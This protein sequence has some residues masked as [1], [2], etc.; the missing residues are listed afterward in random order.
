MPHSARSDRR[1]ADAGG[2]GDLDD[3]DD[4]DLPALREALQ[5][6]PDLPVPPQVWRRIQQ[7]TRNAGTSA[8]AKATMPNR[9]RN[10]KRRVAP[11]ALAAS[12][13]LIATATTLLVLPRSAPARLDAERNDT[14]LLAGGA[15]NNE[16]EALLAQSRRLE[17][18]RNNAVAV[19][20]STD[21][22]RLLRARI[23]GI[24]AALNGKLLDANVVASSRTQLLRERVEL[25]ESLLQIERNG[26]REF[27][28]QAVF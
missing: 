7:R 25:M 23:G 3:R 10:S 27:V 15:P 24:D 8:D 5:A 20:L 21:A 4:A 16:L 17:A 6:L 11:L 14:P 12:V 22:E 13:L 1:R 28:R 26:Q 2:A 9:N 19:V 18:D